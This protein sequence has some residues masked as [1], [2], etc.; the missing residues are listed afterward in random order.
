ITTRYT[1]SVDNIPK[2]HSW[3][4]AASSMST[5]TPAPPPTPSTTP[6]PTAT[7]TPTATPTPI[8][9]SPPNFNAAEASSI[10]V[11]LSTAHN[12]M[13]ESGF[14]IERSTDGT[15]FTQ[16]ATVASNT[17][18]YASAGLN[19]THKY[20]Y[21]VRAYHPAGNSSYSNTVNAIPP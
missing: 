8:P 11:K 5:Q 14:K 18:T 7:A 3:Y 13:N 21:R 10:G 12:A 19:A 9:A 17:T 6:T 4:D 15:T 2:A 16:I 1:L 20:Y